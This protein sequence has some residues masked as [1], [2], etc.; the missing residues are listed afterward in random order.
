[1]MSSEH[2]ARLLQ[3]GEEASRPQDPGEEMQEREPRRNAFRGGDRESITGPTSVTV[4]PVSRGS[5]QRHKTFNGRGKAPEPP[6]PLV[7]ELFSLYEDKSPHKPERKYSV[8]PPRSREAGYG[9]VVLEGRLPET[10]ASSS[11]QRI[12]RQSRHQLPPTV[13]LPQEAR[14]SRSHGSPPISSSQRRYRQDPGDTRGGGGGRRMMMIQVAPGIS[15]PLRGSEETWEA[16][17]QDF[18]VPGMCLACDVTLFV[19]QDAAYVLC[20]DCHCVNAME[21]DF[22]DRIAAGVGLGFKYDDLMRWQLEIVEERR[23]SGKSSG[24]RRH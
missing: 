23:R 17:K 2:G 19:I 12:E 5:L 4:Q 16:I 11:Q 15:A 20:P 24:N 22:V 1:M 18:Y 6:K 7:Q 9:V 10:I 21:G 8:S 3:R 13:P 14:E